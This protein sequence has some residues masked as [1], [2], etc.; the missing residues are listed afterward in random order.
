MI[1]HA[2]VEFGAKLPSTRD[3]RCYIGENCHIKPQLTERL[4]SNRLKGEAKSLSLQIFLGHFR[5]F[6][7][8]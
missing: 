6:C 7:F 5:E 4:Q 3:L 1:L 2:V 8:L